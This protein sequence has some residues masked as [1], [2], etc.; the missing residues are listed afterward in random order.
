MPDEFLALLK[1]TN[2]RDHAEIKSDVKWI[3]E[4]LTPVVFASRK[5]ITIILAIIA[6]TGFWRAV[7]AF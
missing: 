7:A 2:D 1:E 5:A 4:T 6:A 3:R